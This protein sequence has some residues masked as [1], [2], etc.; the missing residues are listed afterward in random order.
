[1][2]EPHL[3]EVKAAGDDVGG[4]G[5]V[6]DGGGLDGERVELVNR[7]TRRPTCSLVTRSFFYASRQGRHI[8]MEKGWLHPESF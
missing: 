3:E 6:Q 2:P 8:Y 5:E 4:L 1:M 7:V